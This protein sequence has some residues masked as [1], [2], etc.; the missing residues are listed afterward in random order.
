L[1]MQVAILAMVLATLPQ[2]CAACFAAGSASSKVPT[3][4]Q[5]CYRS[6]ASRVTLSHLYCMYP[7]RR[8]RMRV[9]IVSTITRY[10]QCSFMHPSLPE[11]LPF[12]C[13][14]L[15]QGA[16]A[17]LLVVGGTIA[18]LAF[19]WRTERQ[20]RRTFAWRLHGKDCGEATEST[21]SGSGIALAAEQ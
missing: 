12:S 6:D 7:F 11:A 1:P 9:Y 20:S 13:P 16:G 18:P 14:Q 4:F 2:T 15:C 10:L 8:Y 3:A 19:M 5:A 21:A 17:V